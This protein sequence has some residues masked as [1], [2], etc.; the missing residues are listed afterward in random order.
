MVMRIVEPASIRCV[1]L[2]RDGKYLAMGA[3]LVV[4]LYRLDTGALC[5]EYLHLAPVCS[6]HFAAEER[7]LASAGIDG[8]IQVRNLDTGT[9]TMHAM[10]RSGGSVVF[11]ERRGRFVVSESPTDLQ[12]IDISKGQVLRRF[13]HTEE[14]VASE[15][16]RCIGQL[17]I[18]YSGTAVRLFDASRSSSACL[19]V[20]TFGSPVTSVDISADETVFLVTTQQGNIEYYD[21]LDGTWIAAQ[22]SFTSPLWGAKFGRGRSIYVSTVNILD[23]KEAV[24]GQIS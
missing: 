22:D 1:A 17:L 5:F 19:K 14:P 4:R 20:I 16:N 2:S 18:A 10:H 9:L 15:P 13:S 23:G 24:F 8:G 7:L 11:L 21:M 12:F 6:V 3:G